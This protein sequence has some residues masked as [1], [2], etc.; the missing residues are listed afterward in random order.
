MSCSAAPQTLSGRVS[1]LSQ[2]EPSWVLALSHNHPIISLSCF[3]SPNVLRFHHQQRLFLYLPPP[4][5][6]SNCGKEVEIS[7]REMW[8]EIKNKSLKKENKI[9]HLYI[10]QPPRNTWTKEMAG[11]SWTLQWVPIGTRPEQK[12]SALQWLLKQMDPLCLF[13]PSPYT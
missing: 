6:P 10:V 13:S 4:G 5:T 8:K 1:I 2:A 9:T 7:Y 3:L 11:N 12:Q